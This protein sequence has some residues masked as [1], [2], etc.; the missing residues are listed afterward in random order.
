M[1]RED[2]DSKDALQIQ[3]YISILD[4]KARTSLD[5]NSSYQII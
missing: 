3:E 1:L 4:N 2:L 5:Y